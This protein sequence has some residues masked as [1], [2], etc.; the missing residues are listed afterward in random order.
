MTTWIACA[1]CNRGGRGNAKDLCSC[2]WRVA[3]VNHHGCYSGLPIVGEPR[4][5]K[6]LSRSK[7]RYQ[8]YLDVGDCFDSFRSFLMYETARE[9]GTR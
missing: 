1:N 2:G 5:P 6:K 9:R 7:Q 3:K 4:Q 8:R